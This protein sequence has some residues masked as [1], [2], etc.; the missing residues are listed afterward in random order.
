MPRLPQFDREEALASAM[1]VFWARGY[2][3]SSIQKLLDAMEINRGSLYASFGDK[4]TLFRKAVERYWGDVSDRVFD[5][6]VNE[7]NAREAIRCYFY[8]AFLD[9]EA[10]R[11]NRGCLL[12]NTVTELSE[13]NPDIARDASEHIRELRGLFYTRL[14]GGQRSGEISLEKDV[15]TLADILIALVAG[16]CVHCKMGA[17]ATDVKNMVNVIVDGL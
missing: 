1:E 13:T 6:L 14:L 9:G 12:F 11:L 8:T 4:E 5:V 15:G 17:N 16:L 2:E 3:A 7:P 10:V